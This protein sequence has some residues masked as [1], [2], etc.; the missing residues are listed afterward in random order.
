MKT[1]QHISFGSLC[2]ALLLAGSA[3]AGEQISS[4]E[5]T[6]SLDV[7]KPGSRASEVLFVPGFD[8]ALGTLTGVAVE[9]EVGM[10][11]TW[12]VENMTDKERV[13]AV[14]G[15]SRFSVFLGP[16]GSKRKLMSSTAGSQGVSN[17]APFDGVFDCRGSSSAHNSF[18]GQKSQTIKFE[19]NSFW[20]K[21]D[22][23]NGAS[24]T[25]SLLGQL[26]PQEGMS[27]C[28][29]T[30]AKATIR[31]NYHYDDGAKGELIEGGLLTSSTPGPIHA[32]REECETPSA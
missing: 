15:G 14:G 19:P 3:S 13:E 6:S 28:I 25:L 5:L 8:P 21:T 1:M 18:T 31:I 22:N 30:D 4:H 32:W 27:G 9:V 20:V 26:L 11:G 2:C 23:P 10:D 17:F 7:N 16:I 12:A 24:L 29:Q